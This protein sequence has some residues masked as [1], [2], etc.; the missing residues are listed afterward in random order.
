[1]LG[2][3]ETKE[4]AKNSVSAS[5]GQYTGKFSFGQ[6]ETI[7]T[8]QNK[9]SLV[10]SAEF[11]DKGRPAYELVSYS[12]YDWYANSIQTGAVRGGSVDLFSYGININNKRVLDLSPNGTLEVSKIALKDYSNFDSHYKETINQAKNAY[13]ITGGRLN[14]AL[15]ASG[16]IISQGD[17]RQHF[18][19]RDEDG[20]PR[21]YIY[22]DKG[23]D[24]VRINNGDDGGGDWILSKDGGLYCPGAINSYFRNTIQHSGYGSVKFL[25]QNT[26]DYILLET[27]QDGKSIY[28]VQR[29]KDENNQWVLHFP[30]KDGTVA[31][32]DDITAN[33][34]TA[35]KEPN[36]WWKCGDT[37]MIIQWGITNGSS[38][39]KDV[40]LPITFPLTGAIA[41][42]TVAKAL[43]FGDD[44]VSSSVSL[45]NNSTIRVTIDYS[46]P[47]AWIA[48]GY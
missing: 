9:T 41:V 44:D 34:N 5:G 37:G 30:Q 14:G 28:F 47:T 17:E 23:G 43:H 22:K 32:I 26:K 42:G 15:I 2:L 13:P 29:N 48:I 38:G 31:T 16:A 7:P 40:A 3:V 35:Q 12:Q 4:L 45:V 19:F 6:I 11:P 27:A 33:K 10:S 24:G 20:R 36:G 39:T 18:S 21:A 46:L 1:N 8:E 25:H